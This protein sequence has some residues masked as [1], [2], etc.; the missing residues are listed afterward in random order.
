MALI[1][2]KSSRITDINSTTEIAA[3]EA[4]ALYEQTAREVMR[5]HPWNCLTARENLPQ[6]PTPAFGWS[7]SYTLPSQCVRLLSVNGYKVE[8]NYV[9]DNYTIEGRDILTNASE[10]K[11]T[12][13]EY[14]D[15]TSLFD[16]HLTRAIAH[17][18]GSYLATIVATDDQLGLVLRDEYERRVLPKAK[19]SDSREQN[20]ILPD[21]ASTS[22]W[23]R[24]RRIQPGGSS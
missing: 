11:I 7:Y 24:A 20:H 3:R 23:V 4:K 1:L 5:E 12:Y 13:I 9:E 14:T 19:M 21:P 6:N 15:D 18:L 8:Q 17:L 16:P 2:C 22:A 10:C